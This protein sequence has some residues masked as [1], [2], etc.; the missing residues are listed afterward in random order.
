MD[1]FL[2]C[3]FGV[4]ETKATI[5]IKRLGTLCVVPIGEAVLTILQSVIV[6]AEGPL[7]VL[8]PEQ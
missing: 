6:R 1:I 8:C 7:N 4:S 5:E 2:G 3:L